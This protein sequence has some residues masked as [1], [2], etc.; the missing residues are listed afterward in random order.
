MDV[1]FSYHGLNVIINDVDKRPHIANK[2]MKKLGLT[3]SASYIEL[4]GE[5]PISDIQIANQIINYLSHVQAHNYNF[6]QKRELT[7]VDLIESLN[8][9]LRGN[10][11][12]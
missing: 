10:K 7:M 3:D 8:E 12:S 5:H 9:A 2:L 11:E 4:G 6:P 1:N